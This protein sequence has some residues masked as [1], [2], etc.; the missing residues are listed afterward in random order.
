[1]AISHRDSFIW[2]S[3]ESIHT[4]TAPSAWTTVLKS[5][6]SPSE[7]VMP[8]TFLLPLPK[9]SLAQLSNSLSMCSWTE[10]GSEVPKM[11]R[12]SS[13]LM[14]KNLGKA[15]RLVSRYSL[16]HFWQV[17]SCSERSCRALSLPSTEHASSTF[18]FLAVSDMIFFHVLSMPSNRLA[19]C[20]SWSLM[21]SDPT[22]M[23]SRYIHFLWTTIHT[24]MASPIRLS[25][26]S[27]KLTSS[28]KGLTNLLAIMDCRLRLMSSSSRMISSVA[29][30]TQPLSSPF[31]MYLARV[32]F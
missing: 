5:N 2:A 23:L 28:R 29:L 24:S 9:L 21:S 18:V 12:S 19:S 3:T 6:F 10:L 31:F 27:Q 25:R 11:E 16:R 30:R 7:E 4:S 13:S 15:L 14:K 26:F 20:G 17:S 8:T 32:N 1:M 22:K